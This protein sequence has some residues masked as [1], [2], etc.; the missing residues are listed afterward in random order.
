MPSKA[1]DRVAVV[2]GSSRGIGRATALRLATGGAA[3]IVNYHTDA[4]SAKQVVADIEAGGG[5]AMTARA[6]AA[7]PT[8][9]RTLLDAAE[10]HYGGLD[11]LVHNAAGFVRT[12]LTAATDGDYAHTF[13]LNAQATFVALREAGRRMRDGGRIVFISSIVTRIDPPGEALYAASKAAGEHLIRTF[14]REIGP[15]GITVNSVLPGPTDTDGFA[16]SSAPVETLIAQTPLGRL[17]EP[18]DIAEVIGFLASDAARWITGQHITV[19]GG[20]S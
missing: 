6:D 16:A 7:D 18:E 4:A 14:A 9:L 11:V 5:R 13:S 12:P 8:E 1:T 20:L 10:H 15:R 19:D 2:T 17:G 3:V